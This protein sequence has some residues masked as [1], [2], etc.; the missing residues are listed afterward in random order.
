MG[1]RQG[2]KGYVQLG[3]QENHLL[4]FERAGVNRAH[5]GRMCKGGQV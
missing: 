4:S 3:Q 1:G 2:C 5:G